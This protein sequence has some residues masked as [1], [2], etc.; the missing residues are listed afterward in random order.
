MIQTLL[1]P[2]S[3][4]HKDKGFYFWGGNTNNIPGLYHKMEKHIQHTCQH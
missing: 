1:S 4:L 2:H 3:Q